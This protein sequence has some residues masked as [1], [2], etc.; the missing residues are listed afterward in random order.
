MQRKDV[1]SEPDPRLIPK[2]REYAALIYAINVFVV[3][4]SITV[5]AM[6]TSS[7]SFDFYP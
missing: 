3:S 6:S 7:S 1:F 5:S 4:V 2:A